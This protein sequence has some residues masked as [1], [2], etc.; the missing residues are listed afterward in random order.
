MDL[1]LNSNRLF[2]IIRDSI[3]IKHNSIATRYLRSVGACPHRARCE[4]LAREKESKVRSSFPTGEGPCFLCFVSFPS[5]GLSLSVGNPINQYLSTQGKKHGEYGAQTAGYDLLFLV[6]N[7]RNDLRRQWYQLLIKNP[8]ILFKA[9][10]ELS[11]SYPKAVTDLSTYLSIHN[12]MVVFI[13]DKEY[14]KGTS[15][16]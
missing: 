1:P 11:S 4:A 3:K 13:I 8:Q 9:Q 12:W 2:S 10:A 6:V 14:S 5:T 16:R 15:I 7:D